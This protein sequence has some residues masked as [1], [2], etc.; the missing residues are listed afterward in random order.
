M[1][2]V[3]FDNNY[4]KIL[5]CERD[6]NGVTKM[7]IDIYATQ[8]DR[9]KEKRII[10]EVNNLK[11]K[12][13]EYVINEY[14][15]INE[16]INKNATLNS[17]DDIEA[18]SNSNPNL[19]NQIK[20]Y[21]ELMSE[22]LYLRQCLMCENINY[23]ALSFKDVWSSLGLTKEMCIKINMIERREYKVQSDALDNL[24]DMYY[25]LK[26]KFIGNSYDC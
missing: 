23:D 20:K 16:E 11:T 2:A 15:K 18:L 10:E 4:Y 13:K 17:L 9:D 24:S 1:M 22:S 25:F 26:S 6:E 21:E 12:I 8:S 14:E 5:G 3:I 19:Y 7:K